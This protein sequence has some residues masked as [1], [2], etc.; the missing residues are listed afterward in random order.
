VRKVEEGGQ[1]EEDSQKS[2]PMVI[3]EDWL[4][5]SQT[6]AHHWLSYSSLLLLQS[7]PNK[8]SQHLRF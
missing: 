5:L 8:S 1:C 3:E 4:E 2:D 6:S 7:W